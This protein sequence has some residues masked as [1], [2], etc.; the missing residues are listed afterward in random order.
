[1]LKFFNYFKKLINNRIYNF[2]YS[3][4]F[5]KINQFFKKL[6]EKLLKGG[7]EVKQGTHNFKGER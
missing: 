6:D 7:E 2:K 3:F 1:M 4:M 5:K